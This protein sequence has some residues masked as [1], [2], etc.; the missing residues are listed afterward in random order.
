MLILLASCES[1]MPTAYPILLF[2]WTNSESV[3]PVPPRMRASG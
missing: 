1:N 3:L 2:L